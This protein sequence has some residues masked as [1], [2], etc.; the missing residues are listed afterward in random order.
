[1]AVLDGDRFGSIQIL[2]APEANET[3]SYPAVSP[4][5]RFVAFVR[6]EGSSRD[7]AASRIQL[8]SIDGGSPIALPRLDRRGKAGVVTEPGNSQ[9]TWAPSEQAGIDWLV[10]ST[11]RIVG[12]KRYELDQLFASAIQLS[13]VTTGEDPSAAAFWLPFQATT[14]GNHRAVFVGTGCARAKELCDGFDDD[15]DGEVDEGCCTPS[16]ERCNGVDDDC[17]GVIDERCGCAPAENCTNGVD[18]DCN[19]D[20]DGADPACRDE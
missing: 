10:F 5:G 1:M 9:P 20:D 4:D 15:C 2:A 6:S 17:D 7:R 13:R 8:V 12:S 14:S 11:T 19:G 3:L 16:E 18:D